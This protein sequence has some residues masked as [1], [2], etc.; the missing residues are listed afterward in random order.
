MPAGPLPEVPR[1][2]GWMLQLYGVRSADSWG[3]GDLA[4]LA[5]FT[6][7]AKSSGA[8]AILVNPLHAVAPVDPLPASPYSPSSRRFVNPLYLRI[9]DL[10]E[11]RD[12]PP[13]CA[14]PSTR[15]GPRCHRTG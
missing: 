13:E 2:W 6:R 15:C 5:A 10:P 1:T 12:A 4:D 7:W 11:Y 9:T 3:V 14:P 8:G